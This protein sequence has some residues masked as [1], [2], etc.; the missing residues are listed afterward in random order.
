MRIR[1]TANAKKEAVG[2]SAKALRRLQ[3][4]AHAHMVTVRLGQWEKSMDIDVRYFLNADIIEIPK[5]FAEAY[6]IPDDITWDICAIDGELYIGPLI[7][8]VV[9]GRTF[10]KTR[11][12][13]FAEH[14]HNSAPA[15]GLVYF[16]NKSGIDVE[17]NTVS[18]FVYAPD[19]EDGWQ[20]GVFPLPN[21]MIRL[22][23]M[24]KKPLQKL[25]EAMQ[26]KVFNSR[27]FTKWEMWETLANAGFAHLPYT[28]RLSGLPE[29][30]QMLQVHSSAYLKPVNGIYGRGIHKVAQAA[31]GYELID[32]RGRITAS[33][34]LQD[35]FQCFSEGRNT[36]NYIVQQ[37]VSRLMENQLIDFRVILQK[38]GTGEWTC[39][40]IVARKGARRRI[41]SN[42]V[43]DVC[44][45]ADALQNWLGMTEAE[46]ER[47]QQAMADMCKEA[48][49][50]IEHAYGVYGDFGMDA[51]VDM[52]HRC[53]L[54]EINVI[55]QHALPLAMAGGEALYKQEVSN[56]LAYATHLAGFGP[57]E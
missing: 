29:L 52:E 16:C 12:T 38:D 50:I 44:F 14:L 57:S 47:L 25:Q 55:H 1:W 56:L 6:S 39:P 43:S 27:R 46:A 28:E 2:L 48:A 4:D 34:T 8:V 21:A 54:L 20:S 32:E 5:S 15:R 51:A 49:K 7:A 10:S 45:G 23:I 30:E 13:S 37:D 35:V 41:V 53:W 31:D 33:G 36:G 22:A 9:R 26:G 19:E 24:K 11:W 42:T 3:L 17:R 18:G 40:G